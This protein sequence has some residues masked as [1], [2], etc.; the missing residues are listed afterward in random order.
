VF[1][2]NCAGTASELANARIFALTSLSRLGR[3]KELCRRQPLY[4]HDAVERGDVYAAVQFRVGHAS[5][6]WLVQDDVEKGRAEASEAMAVWSGRT[7]HIEHYYELFAHTHFDLYAGDF[8]RAR[9][10]FLAKWPPLRRSLL[11]LVQAVRVQALQMR[12]STALA[13]AAETKD[14]KELLADAV[15]DARALER[16]RIPWAVAFAKVVR[17]EVALATRGDGERAARLLRE[18]AAGFE[19]ADMA[20]YAACSR[21]ALGEVLGGDEGSAMVREVDAW[22]RS[23]TVVSP[24][25]IAR[26]MVPVFA[27]RRARS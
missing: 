1:L 10:R 4:V 6:R 15:R 7:F 16:E 26:L 25:R 9:E 20:L 11:L 22:M 12:A 21:R 24:E 17:A 13:L 19:T 5:L 23:E 3:M 14:P 2:R 8:A 18:A 27:L